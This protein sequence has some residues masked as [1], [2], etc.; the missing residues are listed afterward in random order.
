VWKPVDGQC[1]ADNEGAGDVAFMAVVVL[2]GWADSP[3]VDAVGSHVR[4][5]GWSD[6]DDDVGTW[7]GKGALVE[8]EGAVRPRGWAGDGMSEVD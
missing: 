7:W 8:I 1:V 2:D 5:L 3:S 4:T 6:I